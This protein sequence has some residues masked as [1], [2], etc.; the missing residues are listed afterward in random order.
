VTL[1]QVQDLVDNKSIPEAD[2]REWKKWYALFQ[3]RVA[4]YVQFKYC[5]DRYTQDPAY[6]RVLAPI[7]WAKVEPI[8]FKQ[9]PLLDS[10]TP[11]YTSTMQEEQTKYRYTGNTCGGE[12][13]P[14]WKNICT[15]LWNLRGNPFEALWQEWSDRL[16]DYMVAFD[17]IGHFRD[18]QGDLSQR[19]TYE[20]TCVCLPPVLIPVHVWEGTG[21]RQ[22]RGTGHRQ[23]RGAG[24]G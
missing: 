6:I 21:H 18:T 23:G 24:K 10:C 2:R 3:Q 15:I 1:Q 12:Y 5:T 20:K 4:D 8:V 11:S 7:L 14:A 22:G 9:M 16:F 17:Y 13:R 19:I